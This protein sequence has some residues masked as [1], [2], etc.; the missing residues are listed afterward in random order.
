MKNRVLKQAPILSQCKRERDRGNRQVLKWRPIP[1]I[2]LEKR[3][4]I[5]RVEHW[6]KN[7]SPS[8]T[9]V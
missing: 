9:D 3:R 7:R 2:K 5:L 4:Q 6:E 1:Q 8:S